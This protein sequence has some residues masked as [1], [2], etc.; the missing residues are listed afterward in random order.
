MQF[1]QEE[2]LHFL[3]SCKIQQAL[4]I[5]PEKLLGRYLLRDLLK[6]LADHVFLFIKAHNTGSIVA[7]MKKCDI[8]GMYRRILLVPENQEARFPGCSTQL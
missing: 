7:Y 3:N 4:A 6:G 8:I 2:M 1:S 5:D